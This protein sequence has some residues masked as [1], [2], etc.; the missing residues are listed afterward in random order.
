[1]FLERSAQAAHIHALA[2]LTCAELCY[3]R[4]L[5]PQLLG[6]HLPL[7]DLLAARAACS[8]W[9]AA[10]R[11]CVTTIRVHLASQQDGGG[12]SGASPAAL[13]ASLQRMPC[14]A[15]VTLVLSN[16]TSAADLTAALQAVGAQVGVVGPPPLD[17]IHLLLTRLLPA[18]CRPAGVRDRSHHP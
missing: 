12:G 13:A 9:D 15:S 4:R 14:V 10:L 16:L 5:L 3:A 6:S 18:L 8:D 1:V 2:G 17:P 7:S 11:P